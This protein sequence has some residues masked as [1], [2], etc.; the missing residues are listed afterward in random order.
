MALRISTFRAFPMSF[1]RSRRS[2]R[3]R[4]RSRKRRRRRRIL[5]F[6][7]LRQPCLVALLLLCRPTALPRLDWQWP[8]L[9]RCTGL[10]AHPTSL[11]FFFLLRTLLLQFYA[12]L[13][14]LRRRSSFIRPLLLCR[15]TSLLSFYWRW[16]LAPRY[17]AHLDYPPV[18]LSSV[19]QARPAPGPLLLVLPPT[20]NA[21]P[22][23]SLPLR[24]PLSLRSHRL[25]LHLPPNP[26]D[27][28]Q[29]PPSC[30]F[31]FCLTGSPFTRSSSAGPPSN[32]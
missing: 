31:L 18:A 21:P 16:S 4:R 3:R 7:L 2:S 1:Q 13:V 12:A 27:P 14:W 20:P 5:I 17:L 29:N 24:P 23:S 11:R 32:S 15:P 25:A 9:P 30:R 8:L 22:H 28:P 6:W 26:N 10:C 19:S